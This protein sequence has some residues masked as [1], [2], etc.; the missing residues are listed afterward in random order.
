MK[1]L[2]VSRDE[3]F[4]RAIA[5]ELSD[6]GYDASFSTTLD[7]GYEMFV[8][9]LDSIDVTKLRSLAVTFSRTP[10]EGMLCRPFLITDLIGAVEMVSSGSSRTVNEERYEHLHFTEKER[11]LLDLL[12]DN[13]GKVVTGE[14][15]V[16]KV[17][18][19]DE[20]S[21]N[22]VNVYIR[23]LREKLEGNGNRRII[24]TVRGKGYKIE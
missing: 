4:G 7:G 12:L 16:Q 1:I 21:S 14:E 20:E 11:M 15:I 5:I 2:V 22:I 9:D 8:V 24:F 13:R 10:G 6:R 23:Y 19:K 17:W 3:I 18:G